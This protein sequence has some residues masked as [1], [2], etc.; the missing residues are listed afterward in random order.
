MDPDAPR[1]P[2]YPKILGCLYTS[3]VCVSTLT[4]SRIPE[5]WEGLFQTDLIQTRNFQV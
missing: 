4:R 3:P 1:P 2:K 5:T